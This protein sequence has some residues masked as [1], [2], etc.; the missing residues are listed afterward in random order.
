MMTIAVGN[1][2][3]DLIKGREQIAVEPLICGSD[4]TW[5]LFRVKGIKN[6]TWGVDVQKIKHEDL[7]HPVYQ[8]NLIGQ[9]RW[10]SGVF[11]PSQA[12]IRFSVR[13]DD[14]SD[15]TDEDN[16]QFS[17][18]FQRFMWKIEDVKAMPF[19]EFCHYYYRR[20]TPWEKR[21]P[22]SRVLIKTWW[23]HTLSK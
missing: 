23:A 10:F 17:E 15:I 19:I 3:L 7:E 11:R 8:I 5:W 1:K 16:G 13:I 9:H 22:L 6:W 14:D 4:Y 2:I 12:P 21:K 18:V 20:T